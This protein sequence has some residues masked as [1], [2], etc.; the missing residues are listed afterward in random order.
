MRQIRYMTSIA[1]ALEQEMTADPEVLTLGDDIHLCD[2][3]Q[4]YSSA[5]MD[6]V[7]AEP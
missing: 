3:V 5:G 6:S 1:E 7:K 4:R 2:R